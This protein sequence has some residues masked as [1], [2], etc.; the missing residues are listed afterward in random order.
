[1]CPVSSFSIIQSQVAKDAADILN[2]SDYP[3]SRTI[4]LYNCGV[5]LVLVLMSI[6][7][8]VHN[9]NPTNTSMSEFS[10]SLDWDTIWKNEAFMGGDLVV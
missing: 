5:S 4:D 7:E 3:Q 10:N 6:T 1:M 9:D 2:E 8:W